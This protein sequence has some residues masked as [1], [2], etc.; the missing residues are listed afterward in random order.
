[1]WHCAMHSVQF[2]RVFVHKKILTIACN[3]DLESSNIFKLKPYCQFCSTVD[4]TT[5]IISKERELEIN[6]NGC[7]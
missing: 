3:Y 6:Y 4:I 7:F 1:M 2:S 5:S